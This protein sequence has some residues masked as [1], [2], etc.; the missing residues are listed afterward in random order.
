MKTHRLPRPMGPAVSFILIVLLYALAASAA[1]DL[2]EVSVSSQ[3]DHST[4]TIGDLI[5]YTLTVRSA[6]GITIEP[7]EFGENLGEF[8]I[9]DWEILDPQEEELG[10]RYEDRYEIT[11]YKTGAFTI[12][13]VDI[14]FRTT[15][16]EEG[17]VTSE[18]ID[19]TVERVSTTEAEDIRDIKDPL[20]VFIDWR[21]YIVWSFVGL[22]VVGAVLALVLYLRRWS[23]RKGLKPPPPPRPPHE[24][25]FEALDALLA[26]G[27]TERGEIKGYYYGL[28]EIVR[29]YLEGRYR[30]PAME[31]TTSELMRD[32]RT[33]ALPKGMDGSLRGLSEECDLVKFA[34]FVPPETR[35]VEAA[36]TAREVIERTMERAAVEP[37]GTYEE[38]EAKEE[39]P[40][41]EDDR[42]RG[43]TEEGTP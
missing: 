32:L 24:V 38:K 12:P 4:I 21:P 3:V 13:P 8:F 31:S 39:V 18:P 6:Q 19:I 2:G 7:P 1:A 34:K 9:R 41:A 42:S 14:R 30:I 26:Q 25:A 43:D 10:L 11:L 33:V 36:R 22:L 5:Q 23:Q 37:I 15:D 35:W 27:L 17:T 16:G 29:T 20:E 40:G 28:S